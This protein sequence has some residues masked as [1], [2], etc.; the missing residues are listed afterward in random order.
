MQFKREQKKDEINPQCKT[1]GKEITEKSHKP[2]K[3][4]KYCSYECYKIDK[5]IKEFKYVECQ[6]CHKK[7]KETRDRPNLFC[8]R[9]C[10]AKYY[11]LEASKHKNNKKLNND[12]HNELLK[13]YKEKLKELEQ[14]QFKIDHEKYCIVCG[15]F[16]IGKTIQQITCSPE[17]Q[18]RYGN[19]RHD[20]R[21]YRNGKPDLSISLNKVYERDKGIC[22]IC[23]KKIY[24]SDN[25]NADDYPSIDHI[26]PLAKGGLHQWDNVQLACRICNSLK[27]DT[28]SA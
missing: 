7:F 3:I 22:Q 12:H 13:I 21:I 28:E 27:K 11:S 8:S 2:G 10:S 26:K 25:T 23:G 24:F 14:I 1:C 20:K 19:Q 5:N 18:K 17:C 16:F 6:Y 4:R 9:S 15:E